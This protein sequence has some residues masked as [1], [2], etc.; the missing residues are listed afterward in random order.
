TLQELE[1]LASKQE[2]E[3]PS[4]GLSMAPIL[5]PVLM[6]TLNTLTGA[7]GVTGPVAD[8]AGFV[9]N[10]N[11]ALLVSTVVAVYILMKQKGYSL[12]EL[13]GPVE[14]AFASGGLIILI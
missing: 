7:L 8:I 14:T 9:G 4:F 3:L 5:L 11:F 12:T 13:Q 1:A 2:D 10:P 6:I